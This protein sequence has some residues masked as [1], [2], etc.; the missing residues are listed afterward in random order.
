M[1][2]C[3]IPNIIHTS[4]LEILSQRVTKALNESMSP[5]WNFE[6]VGRWGQVKPRNPLWR[7]VVNFWNRTFYMRVSASMIEASKDRRFTVLQAQ[8]TNLRIQ[9]LMFSVTEDG[10]FTVIL[11]FIVCVV[12]IVILLVAIN[13]YVNVICPFSL[14][15]LVSPSRLW[16]IGNK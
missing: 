1:F 12:R 5:N 13:H 14:P 3:L 16:R 7:S 4:P 2:Y 8:T 11:K 6:R 10:Y 9:Q 15:N